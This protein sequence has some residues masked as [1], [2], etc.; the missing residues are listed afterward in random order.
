[1]C[2]LRQSSGKGAGPGYPL[3]ALGDIIIWV[4]VHGALGGVYK[5]HG[6]TRGEEGCSN[7]HNTYRVNDLIWNRAYIR[8]QTQKVK[9]QIFPKSVRIL[10]LK[11][12][13]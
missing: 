6:Q 2:V 10:V 7:D 3:G 9:I 5:P 8:N 1:M 4:L 11:K 12:F 13:A